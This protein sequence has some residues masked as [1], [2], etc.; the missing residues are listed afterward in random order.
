M[1]G[2]PALTI[3]PATQADQ[4]TIRKMIREAGINPMNLKWPNFLVA[5]ESGLTVG[6]GQVKRH[7]DGSPELASLAVVPDRRRQGIGSTLVRELIA[8]HGGEVLYLTCR[9]Q[10]EG[11]YERFGFRRLQRAELP[12]YFAR[13]I[14]TINAIGRLY[15]MRILVMRLDPPRNPPGGDALGP[16]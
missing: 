11:Y 10:L 9:S 13:L 8:R 3:R 1:K 7:G 14:P 6:I 16:S 12:P 2:V 4:P 15:R 5:E